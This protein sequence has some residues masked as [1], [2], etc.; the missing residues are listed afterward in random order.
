MTVVDARVLALIALGLTFLAALVWRVRTRQRNFSCGGVALPVFTGELGYE[1]DRGMPF[2]NA[3]KQRGMLSSVECMASMVPFYESA[4]DE[5]LL[6]VV[7]DRARVKGLGS[8]ASYGLSRSLVDVVNSMWEPPV[9]RPRRGFDSLRMPAGVAAAGRPRFLIHNQ[10]THDATAYAIPSDVMRRMHDMLRPHFLV[11]VVQPACDG[12]D[13]RCG[14]C[15]GM[16]T[17]GDILLEN[18]GWKYNA[19]QLALHEGCEHFVS[20]QGDTSRLASLF[21]GTN[22]VLH[23][24]GM[25]DKHKI[26]HE[27]LSD[28]RVYFAISHD[29]LLKMLSIVVNLWHPPNVALRFCHTPK[30][31]GSAIRDSIYAAAGVGYCGHYKCDCRARTFDVVRHPV[32]RF[33]SSFNYCRNGGT[34]HRNVHDEDHHR[35]PT[36]DINEFVDMLR[37][38]R[39]SAWDALRT[40]SGLCGGGHWRQQAGSNC[41]DTEHACYSPDQAVMQSRINVILKKHGLDPIELPVTNKTIHVDGKTA[42]VSDL[43]RASVIWIEAYYS[44]DMQ[45]WRDAGCDGL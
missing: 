34:S 30:T 15:E 4:F 6:V 19:A 24:G 44:A 35:P 2:A 43:T 26:V 27:M 18:P 11:V 5:S 17:I 37:T 1:L 32:D 23:E 14:G 40:Q 20:L 9:L 8:W 10:P 22:I 12:G 36:D 42:K 13:D 33:V 25:T 41:A 28:V 21:G 16:L 3:L 31:A 39:A 7:P 29:D 38:G 45:L